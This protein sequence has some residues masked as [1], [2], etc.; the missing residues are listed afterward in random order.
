VITLEQALTVQIFHHRTRRNADGTAQRFYRNGKTQTWK[1]RPWAFS[2]PVKRGLYSY[3]RLTQADA[4]DF[5]V[6]DPTDR[7][8]LCHAVDLI[9]ESPDHIL[10][11]CLIEAGYEDVA[12]QYK[13]ECDLLERTRGYRMGA[14]T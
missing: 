11:D 3:G 10:I 12:D 4:E 7:S 13:V 8:S 9:N 6:M 14:K 2:V 1:R 5:L